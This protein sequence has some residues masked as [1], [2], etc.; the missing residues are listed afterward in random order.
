MKKMRKRISLLLSALLMTSGILSGCGKSDSSSESEGNGKIVTIKAQTIGA[1][2]TRVENLKK[3]AEKLNQELK[4]QGKDIQVK[5]ETSSFDGSTD[6]YAKQFMLAFRSKK[7]PDIYATGHENIGWLADGNYILPL[8]ELKQSKAYTDVFPP[9]WEAA[10][11][12]GHIWGALQD[13][14]A[15]PVFYNKD[16]LRK[17]GWSEEEIDRKSVV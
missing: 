1:E 16:V 7:A 5:V 4:E 6:E 15:R 9:L 3:A 13:T 14:E 17:L 11:Y 12:K 8:D 2:V 10:T